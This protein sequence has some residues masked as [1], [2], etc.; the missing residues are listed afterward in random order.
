MAK[1]RR[2]CVRVLLAGASA[3]DATL[4][5]GSLQ[6]YRRQAFKV[7]QVDCLAEA[8]S[9]A[10]KGPF[11]A[12]VLDL[13][14]P[15]SH[16][17]ETCVKMRQAAP[18]MPIVVLADADEEP[19]A[20]EAIH[21]SIQDYVIK[22]P[23]AGQTLG[24]ALYYAVE[25]RR[26]QERLQVQ[27]EELHAQTEEL[28]TQA[29]ELTAAN[30]ELRESE[31]RLEAA[32][33]VA[34]NERQRLEAVM[35]AL[36]VGVAITDVR[37]GNV[38]SNDA[39]EKIWGGPRPPT[40]S[41]SD[42]A[43]Y[44]AWWADTGKTVAPREWAS[45]QVVQTGEPVVGQVM[46]IQRFDGS[47]AF[48]INGAAPVR[49]ATGEIVGSAAALQDITAL[50]EAERRLAYLASFPLRNPNP[51]MEVDASGD[52]RYINPAAMRLFP[53]LAEQGLLHPWLADWASVVGPFRD[54]QAGTGLRD[55]N[56]GERTYQ[57]ALYYSAE[58]RFVRVYGFDITG[59]KRAEQALQEANERLQT[60]AEELRA[61]NEELQ[62]QQEELQS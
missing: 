5:G 32:Y 53:D 24:R 19:V 23:T 48:V 28:R 54:G 1:H 2:D 3:L 58:D 17:L 40:Q 34:E 45:A 37:G 11:D 6:D 57:Q 18:D 13:N 43:A 12:A 26:A 10:A 46:E 27:T 25:H 42:Y 41:V 9:L 21:Q 4:S 39:F 52:I 55:L 35:Q 33:T 29:E 56:I 15:D 62:A 61:T 20:L 31:H 44:Q 50:R 49:D 51:I 47:R 60:Q 59:R 38:Q 16:G 14:L 7:E 30:E 22:G 8:I 36:P